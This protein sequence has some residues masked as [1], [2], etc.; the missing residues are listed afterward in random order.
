MSSGRNGALAKYRGLV[1]TA[2]AASMLT[3][4]AVVLWIASRRDLDLARAVTEVP[5]AWL[6]A[7]L[8]LHMA[9]HAFWAARYALVAQ[10]F[11]LALSGP[12]ALQ[13][14]TAGVF[15]GAVTPGKIGGE[16]LKLAILMRRGVSATRS[17]RL[18]LTDR[19]IDLVFFMVLGLVAA[20]LLP[21][22]FGSDGQAAL[23]FAITGSAFLALFIV[24]LIGLLAFPETTS[25]LLHR[26]VA[27][28]ARLF[29]REPPDLVERVTHFLD[30]VRH[31]V[32]DALGR[33]PG[34]MAAAMA[35][36]A[37][38]W[39]AEYGVLW[40]LLQA[41]GHDVPFWA[42]FFAGIILTMVSN[43]PITPGGTGVAEVTALALLT[44]LAPG[45]SPLFVVAWR[46]VTY[47]YDIVVGGF[48]ATFTV[49]GTAA[50]EHSPD[51]G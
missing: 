35:L 28:F 34:L 13:I 47:Y 15:A 22:L 36:T 37:L 45:L 24:V 18:L 25:S 12:R 44:P 50:L 6:P 40:V 14:V 46:G 43:I 29:R 19:A 11:G 16:G 26:I 9:A 42:V 49:P 48:V 5:W 10:T 21:P 51:A 23:G 31:G 33:R 30:E 7:A 39:I 2:L 4:V 20:A 32:A 38:N 41:M 27:G 17:G 8:A 1:P 3:L